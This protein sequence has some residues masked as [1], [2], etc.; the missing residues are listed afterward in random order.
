MVVETVAGSIVIVTVSIPTSVVT[1]STTVD[2]EIGTDE[3]L[4][5][6]FKEATTVA[7]AVLVVKVELLAD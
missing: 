3:V 4:E 1:T 5:V 2:V 6:V 7:V